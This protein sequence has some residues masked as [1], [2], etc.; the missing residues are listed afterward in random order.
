MTP[1]RCATRAVL[2]LEVDSIRSLSALR[3]SV[4][5]AYADVSGEAVA[6]KSMVIEYEDEEH[7]FHKLTGD[8]AIKQGCLRGAQSLHATASLAPTQHSS[9]RYRS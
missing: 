6:S 5:E 9:R 3:S 4:I 1:T 2:A 8:K 7:T